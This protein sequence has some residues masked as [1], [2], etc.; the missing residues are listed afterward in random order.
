VHGGARCAAGRPRS[1]AS[2][3]PSVTSR[4]N[5]PGA[6]GVLRSARAG[7]GAAANA[8]APCAPAGR[9]SASAAQRACDSAAG[10]AGSCSA[11][12]GAR[13]G[14][15]GAA[16]AAAGA[17]RGAGG[18]AAL[19]EL[20]PR[21][22]GAGRGAATPVLGVGWG[23]DAGRVAAALQTSA[24]P[25]GGG[26]QDSDGPVAE[27][28]AAAGGRA[29][30]AAPAEAASAAAEPRAGP[31]LASGPA[32]TPAAALG[33]PVSNPLFE[34]AGAGA[35][36]EA[37]AC[38]AA[39]AAS[40]AGSA[41]CSSEGARLG[42]APHAAGSAAGAVAP[43]ADSPD[44]RG[45]SATNAQPGAAGAGRERAGG[46]GS[47]GAR[48]PPRR[49]RPRR[50]AQDEEGAA[51]G[52]APFATPHR[53]APGAG[54]AH[55][56]PG[57]WQGGG[58]ASDPAEALAE[59]CPDPALTPRAAAAGADLDAA[60]LALAFENQAMREERAEL[61]DELRTISARVR[62]QALGAQA[63][64]CQVEHPGVQSATERAQRSPSRERSAGD[65]PASV[66]ACHNAVGSHSASALGAHS[67][68]AVTARRA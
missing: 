38:G 31:I 21:A 29:H 9:P 16:P 34:A 66:R 15:A 60:P 2:S 26:G 11:G 47:A 14:A 40:D 22:A 49:A 53:A 61:K 50:E 59:R 18:A 68:S 24:G 32:G 64:L 17:R 36:G 20:Q 46:L 13:P 48:S 63:A 67:A 54:G 10:S 5:A 51:A 35:A 8:P 4:G 7:G 39:A 62:P 43:S 28:P 27:D 45:A 65:A 44:G 6:E 19:L 23:L 55:G 1:R 12:L 42:T 3:P 57:G 56:L 30:A 52:W 37:A 58:G 25:A 41:A 33:R